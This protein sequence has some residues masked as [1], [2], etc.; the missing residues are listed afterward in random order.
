MF[1]SNRRLIRRI[2]AS[3]DALP[4]PLATVF[5]LHAAEGLD[6][7]EIALRLDLHPQEVERL[8]AEAIVA[9]GRDLARSE[10]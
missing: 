5:R 4:G 7:A 2:R 8:L 6:Y 3:L 9:I 1:R 10:R